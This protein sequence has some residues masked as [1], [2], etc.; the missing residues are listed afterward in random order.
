MI[1]RTHDLAAFTTLTAFVAYETVPKI[2][3]ATAFVA[4]GANMIGGLMPDIDDATSEFWQKIPAGTFIGKIIHPL[5]GH[6]RMISHSI[7]GVVIAGFLVKHLLIAVNQ[8]LI[9][10]MSIVWWGL[11]L[12][13]V[14]HLIMDSLTVEGVPWFFPIPVRLGFP[15]FKFLRVKT[16]SWVETILVF[17][18]LLVLNCYLVYMNYSR[19]LL[20]FRSFIK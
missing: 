11:M 4:F 1:G 13:Y 9:V 16:G 12:G 14:S 8:V 19:Y 5:I 3:L 17:P 6:H 10:D 18:G 15:P 7:V 2:T 20:F